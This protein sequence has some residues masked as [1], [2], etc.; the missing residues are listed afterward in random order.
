MAPVLFCNF[1]NSSPFWAVFWKILLKNTIYYRT[2]RPIKLRF[3]HSFQRKVITCLNPHQS[4]LSH[5]TLPSPQYTPCIRYILYVW[6]YVA[7]HNYTY[8]SSLSSSLSS[9]HKHTRKHRSTFH[10]PVRANTAPALCE[11]PRKRWRC[12]E[13]SII[14]TSWNYSVQARR[15]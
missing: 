4:P 5:L 1:S 3:K 14:N 15:L 6:V 13:R 9:T 2:R 12:C 7:C 10:E 11:W 8:T